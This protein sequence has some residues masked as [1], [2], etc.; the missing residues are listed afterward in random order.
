MTIYHP[1]MPQD[2]SFVVSAWSSSLRLSDRAGMIHMDDWATV[3][4]V[5]IDKVLDR[6]SAVTITACDQESMVIQ[7]FVC[8]D[9]AS[10][11]LPPIVFYIY[12]K[13]PYRRKGIARGLFAAIGVDPLQ[14]F[15][16]AC[17]TALVGL[18]R[19]KIPGARHDH[20]RARFPEGARR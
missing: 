6:P 5:Q 17:R 14:P 3:M 20:L 8:A 7:G 9:V 15:D 10:A 18:L 13:E 4:H 19:D 2:R 1:A 12:V 16:Y 11:V